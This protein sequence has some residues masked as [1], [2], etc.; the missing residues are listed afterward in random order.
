[1]R[2]PVNAGDRRHRSL[3]GVQPWLS[4][5]AGPRGP[6]TPTMNWF[7]IMT[8]CYC[9]EQWCITQSASP[10]TSPRLCDLNLAA[11]RARAETARRLRTYVS[12]ATLLNRSWWP[13]IPMPSLL[14]KS[15]HQNVVRGPATSQSR[16]KSFCRTWEPRRTHLAEH[17]PHI[18]D[19]IL[20]V[21]ASGMV[22]HSLLMNVADAS[23]EETFQDMFLK[24]G[25]AFKRAKRFV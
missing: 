3:A 11:L 16:P 12:S 14:M 15:M 17:A 25:P 18:L 5:P 22:F 21:V 6:P 10:W 13:L 4:A 8:P 1:M 19:E 2:A 7:V 9:I 23:A 20:V 24:S